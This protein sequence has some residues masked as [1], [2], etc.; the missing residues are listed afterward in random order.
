MLALAERRITEAELQRL[1]RRVDTYREDGTLE[2]RSAFQAEF[3]ELIARATRNPL[4]QHQVRWWFRVSREIGAS[5]GPQI[6]RIPQQFYRELVECLRQ[7]SGAVQIWL[8]RALVLCAWSEEQPG[9]T[10][11]LERRRVAGKRG[12]A[13]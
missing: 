9:H 7:R 8:D 2:E 10:L 13:Q 3:W 12:R 4:L 6:A 11:Q 5:R 1:A